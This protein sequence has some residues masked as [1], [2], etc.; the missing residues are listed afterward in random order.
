MGAAVIQ[1]APDSVALYPPRGADG[2]GWALPGGTPS[3]CGQ[4]SLQGLLGASDATAGD[5]GGHGPHDPAAVSLANL[6]LPED[7]RPADGMTARVRGRW[8]SLTGVRFIPDPRGSGELSCWV[9]SAASDPSV[10]GG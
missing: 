6:Y 3:W 1:L 10:P 7:A 2:H 9:A 5:R 8:W 4:G